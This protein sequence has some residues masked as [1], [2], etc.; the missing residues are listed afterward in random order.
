MQFRKLGLV[1]SSGIALAC[2]SVP[3]RA[4]AVPEAPARASAPDHWYGEQTLAVDAA[5]LAIGLGAYGATASWRSSTDDAPALSAY[6]ATSLY[7]VG[8]AA[9]PI[10]HW[11]NGQVGIGFADLGLRLALPPVVGIIGIAASCTGQEFRDCSQDGMIG[12][13]LLGAAAVAAL[14]ALVLARQRPSANPP[15][16]T[17]WYG[18][19]TLI[20][21]GALLGVASYLATRPRDPP[22]PGEHEFSDMLYF[23]LG[24]YSFSAIT[25]PVVHFAHGRVGIGFADF[26][27]RLGLPLVSVVPG[28]LVACSGLGGRDGCTSAGIEGGILGGMILASGL[29]AFVFARKRASAA[30][31]NAPSTG[32]VLPMLTPTEGGAVVGAMGTF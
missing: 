7:G 10:V 31:A 17:S 1:L 23:A 25:A 13:T 11:A 21:D 27:V 22:D 5:A 19:Q 15:P 26:G 28:L 2:V 32:S 8:L 29:D 9:A 20:V 4:D 12:G 24:W 16:E 14:D 30:P 6:L 3:A 18:W